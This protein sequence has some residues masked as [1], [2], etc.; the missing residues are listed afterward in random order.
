[1]AEGFV[2][3]LHL[4]PTY[5][6]RWAHYVGH[7]FRTPAVRLVEHRAG[8]GCRWTA[9]AR[10]AGSDFWLGGAWP[11]SLADEYVAKVSGGGRRFCAICRRPWRARLARWVVFGQAGD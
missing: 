11:G 3:V 2:Y 1:M 8:V 4:H 7:T 10:R 9:R 6:G 5:K